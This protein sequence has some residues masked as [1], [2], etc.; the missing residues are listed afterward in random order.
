MITALIMAG[1][2]GTRFWPLSRADRPKQFLKLT[3]DQKTML[4]ATVSRIEKLVPAD[5]IFVA[6]NKNY[7]QAIYRQLPELPEENIIIE[8]CKRDTAPCIGLASLFIENKVPGSTMVVLPADHLIKDNDRFL[9]VLEKA[10]MVA[11]GE[12]NLVTLG[13]RPTHPE[14]GYGYIHCGEQAHRIDDL[15]VYRVK[16]FTEKP[17]PE[18]ARNFM[19]D[20]TYLWNSGMFIWRVDTILAKFAAFMPELYRSLMNIKKVLGTDLEAGVIREEFNR[21]KG[22]S[23]DYGIMEKADSIFVI[24]GEF[25]WDD[26]G[27]WPALERIKKVDDKGNVI[28]GKHYGIDTENTIIHSPDRVVTTI[29]LKDIVIVDTEDAIL[30]CDKKRAQEVKQIREILQKNGL[31]NFL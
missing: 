11:A 29:G 3:D 25:G 9:D 19:E 24:P 1:G 12:N 6:T 17:G 20:G 5:R 14:T 15:P 31:E 13:I 2:Q 18:L 22:T 16:E 27:S 7:S 28:L 10:V 21:M 26:L 23:I 4:Q 8:P 30:I